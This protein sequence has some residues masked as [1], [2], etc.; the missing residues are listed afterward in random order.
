MCPS[1]LPNEI[2]KEKIK[3]VIHDK[4]FQLFRIEYYTTL[5]SYPEFNNNLVSN[6]IINNNEN[7]NNFGEKVEFDFLEFNRMNEVDFIKK[8]SKEFDRLNKGENIFLVNKKFNNVKDYCLSCIKFILYNK[9]EEDYILNSDIKYKGDYSN[10]N[11][12]H[13]NNC[14][15]FIQSDNI[16]D[17]MLIYRFS[18]KLPFIN[19][20]DLIISISPLVQNKNNELNK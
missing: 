16:L 3:L 17:F 9:N 11:F 19:P 12:F 2:I 7:F 4:G 1:I 14:V 5:I 8:L 10:F 13:T 15:D 6:E 18:N 20:N